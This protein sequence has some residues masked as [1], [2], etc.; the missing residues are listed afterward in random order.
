M[1]LFHDCITKLKQSFV[2]NGYSNECFDKTLQKYLRVTAN[3]TAQPPETPPTTHEVFYKNQFNSS[4]KTDER[5]LKDLVYNNVRCTNENEKLKLTIYYARSTTASLLSK[6][7]QSPPPPSLQRTNL[8]YE[9]NCNIDECERQTNSYVGMT[10]TTLSR[11]LTM[12]LQSGAPK[13]HLLQVHSKILT[14]EMLVNNTKI[15]RSE[16]NFTRLQIIEALLI[17]KLRPQI[18]I[19]DTGTCRTL[20]LHNVPASAP[21]SISNYRPWFVIYLSVLLYFI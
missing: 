18:N 3:K 15:I 17:Q 21:P 20:L 13:K 12:H 16:S 1:E 19:Q 6:N 7:N 4:Y 9:Y 10:T 8:I 2:N 5:I 14:R 11:R